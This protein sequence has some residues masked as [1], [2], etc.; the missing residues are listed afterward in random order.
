MKDMTMQRALLGIPAVGCLIVAIRHGGGFTGVRSL[1][2]V[3]AVVL[4]VTVFLAVLPSGARSTVTGHGH[5]DTRRSIARHEA[6]HA[7]AARQLGG[8]VRS[9]RMYSGTRG[10]LVQAT[11]PNGS[12]LAVVTFLVAGQI[13]AETSEGSGGDNHHIRQ[14]LR[15]LPS[16]QARRIRSQ[17]TRDARRMVARNP[18]QL[19]RDAARL[20][21][22][23]R[24]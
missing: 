3:A 10:G 8:R 21:E 11:L 18:G 7:L 24:L 1:L 22:A 16:A 14:E 17:A 19:N 15:G 13:A 12:P 4:V 9:A 23:G 6:G 20:E 2:I 5:G